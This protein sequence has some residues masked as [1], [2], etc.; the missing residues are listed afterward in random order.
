MGSARPLVNA[1]TVERSSAEA[2]TRRA[3]RIDTSRGPVPSCR[4]PATGAA[5]FLGETVEAY[6]VRADPAVTAQELRRHC[7]ERLPSYKVPHR[8]TFLERLPRNP[9]GKVVKAE[10]GA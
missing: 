2:E 1:P 7:F 10:L 3:L 5:A 6:V 4:A 9:S 8:V